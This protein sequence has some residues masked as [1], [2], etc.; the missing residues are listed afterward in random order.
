[1]KTIGECVHELTA[2]IPFIEEGLEEGLINI[3]ALARKLQPEVSR[4]LGKTV[5]QGA[6]VMAIQRRTPGAYLKIRDRLKKFFKALGD[7]T[8]RSDLAE[9]TYQNSKG[10]F[11]RHAEFLKVASSHGEFF[12]TFSQGVYE[13][14][15]IISNS[16]APFLHKILKRE[17]LLGSLP[18]LSSVTLRLPENNVR[19][20]GIYYFILHRLA[21]E[22][23]N[24]VE[25]ISTQQEF[26]L[27]VK[28]ADTDRVFSLL[29][30]LKRNVD[31][32]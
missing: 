19:I 31:V 11:E 7:L 26:T 22:G 24:I 1:L 18:K 32:F 17:K 2:G 5:Q 6:I 8:V 4:M 9:Y 28:E 16:M 27:V 20:A 14:T 13:S 23:I 21:R 3:S 25:V 10:L 12:C 15:I 30:R 29:M